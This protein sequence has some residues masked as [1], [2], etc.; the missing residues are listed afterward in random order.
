MGIAEELEQQGYE[1]HIDL[2]SH[3]RTQLWVNRRSGRGLRLE[4]FE[5]PEARR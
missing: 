4:S 5:L 3:E 2:G 1:L